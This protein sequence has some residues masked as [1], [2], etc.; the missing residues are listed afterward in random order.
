M[1]KYLSLKETLV[2]RHRSRSSHFRDIDAGLC[3][4]GI[5]VGPRS[6]V[7]LRSEIEHLQCAV[8]A[9]QTEC[10]IRQLVSE[11]HAKRI[12]LLSELGGRENDS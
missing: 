5:N 7:W 4:R 11:M 1:N 6:K 10:D 8:I 12:S 2:Y 9:G 3:P